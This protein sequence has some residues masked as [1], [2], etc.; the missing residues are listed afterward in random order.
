MNVT[1]FCP[2]PKNLPEAKMKSFE[3]FPLIK[4]TARQPDIDSAMWLFVTTLL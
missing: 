2:S 3:L 1:A 4:E